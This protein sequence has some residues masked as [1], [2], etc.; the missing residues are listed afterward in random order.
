MIENE[1]PFTPTFI[2]ENLEGWCYDFQ[3]KRFSNGDFDIVV[4]PT[5]IQFCEGNDGLEL[6]LPQTD[7]E[8]EIYYRLAQREMPLFPKLIWRS[9]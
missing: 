1:R 9:K 8:F 2:E 3:T 6:G 5:M 7:V 4:G